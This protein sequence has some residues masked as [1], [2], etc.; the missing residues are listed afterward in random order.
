M[1]RIGISEQQV[2]EA[3]EALLHAGQ[4]VTVS[5]VRE[6][7]GSGS[8]STINGFLAKWKE[9]NAD[10]KP[11]DV[12]DM[13][14]SV[15]RAMR[16]LWASAWKEGQDG[17]KAEREALETARR[18]MERE[19]RDMAHEIARLETETTAQ[20]E[21]LAKFT[22]TLENK[23]NALE[24]V[25]QAANELKIENARLDERAKAAE[26]RAGELREELARLHARFQE[27]VNQRKRLNRFAPPKKVGRNRLGLIGLLN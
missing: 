8:F 21:E 22:E 12:P 17:I 24:S 20:A 25:E 11:V 3:A 2:I 7:I 14:D 16:Q 9:S 1:A 23:T 6:A 19:R 26:I 5:A 27:L 4:A 18:D 13:P 10:R 15:S